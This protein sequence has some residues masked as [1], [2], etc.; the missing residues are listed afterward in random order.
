MN[1]GWIRSRSQIWVWTRIEFC[2]GSPSTRLENIIVM[3]FVLLSKL[4]CASIRT[5]YM[6]DSS[7]RHNGHDI[8]FW[9]WWGQKRIYVSRYEMKLMKKPHTYFSCRPNSMLLIETDSVIVKGNVNMTSGFTW[10]LYKKRTPKKR[11]WSL[12]LR[13]MGLISLKKVVYQWRGGWG[14][15]HHRMTLVRAW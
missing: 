7:S 13:L 1:R 6:T 2:C 10:T 4:G 3:K 8:V 5:W 15:D 9:C 11:Y 14:W 12:L